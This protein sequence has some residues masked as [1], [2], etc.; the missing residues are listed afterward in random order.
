MDYLSFSLVTLVLLLLLLLLFLL[1]EKTF[2][3][4]FCSCRHCFKKL[5]KGLQGRSL[6]TSRITTLIPFLIDCR[7]LTG[8]NKPIF[9]FFLY[10]L[11]ICT[12]LRFERSDRVGGKSLTLYLNE[13]GECVQQKDPKS[14]VVAGRVENQEQMK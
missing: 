7:K 13:S 1:L 11:I 10:F 5:V 6:D 8:F 2:F 3:L 12:I 9:F 14:G 4:L